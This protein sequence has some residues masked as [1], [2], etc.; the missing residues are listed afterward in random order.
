MA[1]DTALSL[2]WQGKRTR[3]RGASRP[4]APGRLRADGRTGADL[5][6]DFHP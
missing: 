1:T 5:L 4:S 6:K 3:E 2:S